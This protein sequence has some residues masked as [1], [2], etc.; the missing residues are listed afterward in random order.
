MLFFF[1]RVWRKPAIILVDLMA[2]SLKVLALY[3]CLFNS[4][5]PLVFQSLVYQDANKA[6]PLDVVN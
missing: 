6:I 1:H 5:L 4:S 2:M 3:W